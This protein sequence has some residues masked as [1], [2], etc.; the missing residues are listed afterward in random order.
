MF[1]SNKD[2]I[3]KLN[4][5]TS[6]AKTEEDLKKETL[7]LFFTARH[8]KNL[9]IETLK[10]DLDQKKTRLDI[11]IEADDEEDDD[12]QKY[13]QSLILE[14]NS[15]KDQLTL[16]QS[17]LLSLDNDQKTINI[18][19]SE[20][21]AMKHQKS[22]IEYSSLLEKNIGLSE[23]KKIAEQKATLNKNAIEK[24][25][26]KLDIK[27]ESL[28]HSIEA[29][30]LRQMPSTNPLI[31]S[32]KLVENNSLEQYKMRKLLR[33]L[34]KVENISNIKKPVKESLEETLYK[35][36]EQTKQQQQS[37]Q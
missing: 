32:N 27:E 12:Q 26:I 22:L 15:I 5:K 29:E 2:D 25:H 33:S 23:L 16:A 17:E 37:K 14:I 6:K 9:Q 1:T 28:K 10:R 13:Q 18:Y 21:I 20:V 7:A 24:L 19:E 30:K 35:K 36:I 31:E 34:N 4:I 11:S 8:Q 3:N